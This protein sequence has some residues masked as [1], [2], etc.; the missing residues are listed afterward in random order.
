MKRHGAEF[1][2]QLIPFGAGVFFLPAPTK[3]MN[4]KAAPKLSYGVFLGYRLAPGGRWNGEYVVADLVD[5]ANM[6]LHVDAPE[7]DC[8]IPKPHLTE[9]V[10]LHEKSPCFPLKPRYESVNMTLSG[11]EAFY[12]QYIGYNEFGQQEKHIFTKADAD[13][14]ESKVF[15]ELFDDADADDEHED[16]DPLP[17]TGGD[18]IDPPV[19]AETVPPAAPETQKYVYDS[20]GRKFKADRFGTKQMKSDR[21][22]T[23]PSELWNMLS[24]VEKKQCVEIERSRRTGSA[25]P[26][27]ER[28]W[29][30][31]EC[32]EHETEF[33]NEFETAA[34]AWGRG[35]DYADKPSK[36][37]KPMGGTPAAIARMATK[38]SDRKHRAKRPDSTFGHY[39][40]VARPGSKKEIESNPKCQTAMNLEWHRLQEKVV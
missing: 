24:P 28:E 18:H 5:F 6:S 35:R 1:P 34:A 26:S 12:N 25:V 29:G 14:I 30:Y 27:P 15:D 16:A 39:A 22:G 32:R 37:A 3:G 40:C 38:P 36:T 33:L 23:V 17:R 9:Q 21:P 20:L 4:S 19:A 10:R 2:G 7:T 8:Y 13:A 31:D 11:H